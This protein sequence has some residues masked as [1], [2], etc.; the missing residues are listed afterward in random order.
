MFPGAQAQGGMFA[1]FTDGAVIYKD[2]GLLRRDMKFKLAILR[3]P[4]DSASQKK[5]RNE[6]NT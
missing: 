5:Q 2:V 3:K 4:R 1:R 6:D